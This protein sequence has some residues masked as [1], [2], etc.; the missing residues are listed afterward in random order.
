MMV[1]VKIEFVK[2]KKIY[3]FL[4]FFTN[5]G[6]IINYIKKDIKLLFVM[7]CSSAVI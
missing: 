3:T 2:K 5:K 1:N 4:A 6:S 7:F